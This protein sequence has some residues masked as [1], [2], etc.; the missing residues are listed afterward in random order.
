MN[1]HTIRMA[2]LGAAVT[3]CPLG[4]YAQTPDPMSSPASQTS[5]NMPQQQQPAATSMQDSSGGMGNAAETMR[6]KMFLR[7]AAAGGM[8][9]VQL[10]QLAS[11][12]AQGE[13]VKAFGQKMVTDHTALNEQMKPIA[14]S[15]GVSAPK[16]LSKDDQAEYDKLNGLSGA[17][18][19]T[20]Y[21]T[22]MVKDH[23]KDLKEFTEAAQHTSD[24]DL[25]EAVLKGQKM[26]Q[27]HTMIVDKLAQAKGIAVPTAK[28]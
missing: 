23:H 9:E 24:P 13:D 16:K 21:L 10:G 7:K 20:E 4:L 22:Y 2:L 6:E 3:L 17:E 27:H 19:D 15:K 8:A 28:Q 5:P 18:F 12:K 1:K 14:E 26:I 25:K 11:E